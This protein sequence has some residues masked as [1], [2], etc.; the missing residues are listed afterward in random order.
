MEP[1][2]ARPKAPDEIE[3]KENETLGRVQAY[4]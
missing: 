3:C 2:A 4:D 1:Q